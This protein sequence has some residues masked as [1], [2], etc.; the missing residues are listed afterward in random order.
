MSH[1]LY[2]LF[3][4]TILALLPASSF[5][6]EDLVAEEDVTRVIKLRSNE[7]P[8]PPTPS[9]D[10]Q[11][12]SRTERV[13]KRTVD[14][15][16]PSDIQF[17]EI[18]NNFS[19][20][21]PPVPEGLTTMPEIPAT[22]NPMAPTPP[23]QG[24]VVDQQMNQQELGSTFSNQPAFQNS[25]T[26]D[27]TQPPNAPMNR[28]APTIVSTMTPQIATKVLAPRFVNIKENTSVTIQVQNVSRQPAQAVK[29]IATLPRHVKFASARPQPAKA[30]GQNYEFIISQLG[31]RQVHEVQLTLIPNQKQPVEVATQV[32]VVDAQKVTVG[33]RQPD[34]KIAVAGSQEAHTGQ[35]IEHIVTIENRGDGVAENIQL[36]RQ[37]PNQLTAEQGHE[38]HFI[39][40]LA[41]GQKSQF[42]TRTFCESEGQYELGFQMAARN[43]EKQFATRP[44]QVYRPEL[45]VTATGPNMNFVN[46]DGIYTIQIENP[47]HVDIS[48]VQL[49]FQVPAGFEVTTI[50]RKANVNPKSGALIWQFAK[51]PAKSQEA[52]QLKAINKVAGLHVCKLNVRSNETQD[53]QIR[54]T[55]EVATRADVSINISN[56]GG[57]V[58]VGGKTEL[59]VNVFNQGSSVASGVEVEIELAAS[60]MPVSRES[61]YVDEMKNSIRF[62]ATEIEPGKSQEF[63]FG[64]VGVNEGEHIVRSIVVTGDS[65]RRLMAEDSVY[66]FEVD[67][68]KVSES[69]KP[70]IRR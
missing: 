1:Q 29:L 13:A 10:I 64:A 60:L 8:L 33:V 38:D 5:A 47:G 56:E 7:A 44:L 69:S 45:Q 14:L 20:T 55:T 40:S 50:S 51:I 59:V 43:M 57:P 39:R 68:S 70:S 34:L 35:W 26:A 58:E 27:F 54:L 41:P 9:V 11:R 36:V 48:N 52:I 46:R 63:R 2:R 31:P 17:E 53:Q 21:S 15:P 49:D 25:T 42:K 6:Q 3:T 61:Y 19:K 28:V 67:R 24:P 65:K 16:N 32:M 66:V 37:L 4:V 23:T 30:D 18:G 62:D 12:T 22:P